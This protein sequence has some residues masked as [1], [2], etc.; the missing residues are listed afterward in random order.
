MD[1]VQ[2]IGL[3]AFILIVGMVGLLVIADK[4][5]SLLAIIIV[6]INAAITSIP[7]ILALTQDTQAGMFLMP[8]LL[9]NVLVKVD[10]LSAWF[11]LIINF[12]SING[13]LYGSGY[14][15]SYSNLKVNRELHWVFYTLF[16]ISMV[17]CSFI[18]DLSG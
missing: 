14:L 9:G 3:T 10:S 8:H 2:L 13:A 18:S 7:A 12:T 16:H 15:K 17:K 5:K 6:L 1:I 4:Y 11:I